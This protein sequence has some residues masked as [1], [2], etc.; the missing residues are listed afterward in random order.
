MK[1]Q[2]DR[3]IILRDVNADQ[4][5]RFQLRSIQRASLGYVRNRNR[6]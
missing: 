1:G 3:A 6:G 2:R 5:L 4:R